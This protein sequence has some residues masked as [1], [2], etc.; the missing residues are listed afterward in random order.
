MGKGRVR[1]G[2]G[3]KYRQQQENTPDHCKRATFC[4]TT[5]EIEWFPNFA[6]MRQRLHLTGQKLPKEGNLQRQLTV[7]NLQDWLFPT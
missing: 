4:G 6:R 5:V 7:R 1:F 3:Y 2:Q